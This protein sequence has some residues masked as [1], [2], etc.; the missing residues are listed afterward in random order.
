MVNTLGIPA[1]PTL[2]P[3]YTRLPTCLLPL[4]HYTTAPAVHAPCCLVGRVGYA[5]TTTPPPPP[6]HLRTT[7]L[8]GLPHSTRRTFTLRRLHTVHLLRATPT[9]AYHTTPT[10]IHAYLPCLATHTT[11]TPQDTH[12]H[13]TPHAFSGQGGLRLCQVLGS[14]CNAGTCSVLCMLALVRACRTVPARVV[15]CAFLA[16]AHLH[17]HATTTCPPPTPPHHHTPAP[18]PSHPL[19]TPPPPTPYTPPYTW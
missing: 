2:P 5:H 13:T 12:T 9:A 17:R 11:H 19:P 15:P 3:A 4:L 14:L 8:R 10:H 18:T 6:L 16:C 1:L 7:Y